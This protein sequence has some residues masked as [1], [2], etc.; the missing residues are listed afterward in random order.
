[1][2]KQQLKTTA[3]QFDKVAQAI[4]D[5][6]VKVQYLIEDN[7]AIE[8]RDLERLLNNARRILL[9]AVGEA[10]QAANGHWA[11]FARESAS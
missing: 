3:Q 5:I 7:H 1:V 11:D 4:Q 6:Q 10:H 8:H 2:T 9:D